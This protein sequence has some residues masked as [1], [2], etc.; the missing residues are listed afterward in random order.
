MDATPGSDVDG[1]HPPQ[2][3][4]LFFRILAQARH[5]FGRIVCKPVMTKLVR[6]TWG[7]VGDGGRGGVGAEDKDCAER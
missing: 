5:A 1:E 6:S 4:L 7:S 3:Y 2:K